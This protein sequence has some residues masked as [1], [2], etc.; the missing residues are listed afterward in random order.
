MDANEAEKI[1]RNINPEDIHYQCT[2]CKEAIKGEVC[3]I[4]V[5]RNWNKPINQQAEQ[6]FFSHKACFEKAAGEMIEVGPE[7]DEEEEE[8]ED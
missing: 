8:E 5:V 4:V 6:M 1:L 7:D 2:F 3:G